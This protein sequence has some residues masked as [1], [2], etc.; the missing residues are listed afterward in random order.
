MQISDFNITNFNR[1]S[2]NHI[3]GGIIWTTFLKYWKTVA[4]LS[5]YV[6]S[7]TL[8]SFLLKQIDE[9]TV[10][11]S[12]YDLSTSKEPAG[13]ESENWIMINLDQK[14]RSEGGAEE[15][16]MD[17]CLLFTDDVTADRG[18]REITELFSPL[19]FP[20]ML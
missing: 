7:H 19:T 14:R 16:D 4:F 10:H 18:R 3:S 1:N 20:R 8:S 2:H 9:F 5:S 12:V 13:L 11:R 6:P 17:T 15:D